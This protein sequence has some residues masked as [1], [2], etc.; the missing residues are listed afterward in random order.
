MNGFTSTAV[1]LAGDLNVLNDNNS[2]LSAPQKELL[3]WHTRLGH[4]SFRKVQHL[5][6]MGVLATSE[7]QRRLH[8][9]ASRISEYSHLPK[10]AACQ[11]GKQHS[12]PVPGKKSTAIRDKAGILSADQLSPGQRIHMDHFVS[13]TRGRTLSGYGITGRKAPTADNSFCGGCIFVDASSSYVHVE[14]QHHL[15]NKDTLNAVTAFEQ[16]AADS[17]VTVAEYSTDNGSC[18]TS[19]AFAAHLLSSNQTV[20]YSGAG[21]HHQNGVAERAIQTIM[22]IARTML[23]HSAIH[24]PDVADPTL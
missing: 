1:S 19:K 3:F 24:W 22:A 20:R 23:L 13:S 10:C 6:R 7:R 17:G 9:A 8:T 11:Y 16:E 18:F 5:M 12:K 14:L 15:N 21:S 2:N 4:V